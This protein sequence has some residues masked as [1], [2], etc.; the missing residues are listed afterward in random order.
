MDR[1]LLSHYNTELAHLRETAAEFAREFPK[2]ASRLA[3]DRDAKEICADPYVERLLEG[4][5]FLAARVQV[6][7]E[8]QFPKFTHGLLETV[9][10]HYLCPTPS[11]AIVQLEPILHDPN[12]AGGF[13]LPR[14]TTL[15]S[16][17]RRG[18]RTP[19]EYKTAHALTLWPIRIAE[20]RYHTRELLQFGLPSSLGA[21]AIL[22]I[23]LE[24]GAGVDFAQLPL[25]QLS[26]YIRGADDLPDAIFE[27]VF[28]HAT[29][30]VAAKPRTTPSLSQFRPAKQS[31]RQAGFSADQALLPE[32]SQTFSGYRLLREYFAL[33]QRFL[34]FEVA[35][36]SPLLAQC[37]GDALDLLL[38]FRE[39]DLRLENRV[40]VNSL[41]LFCTPAINLFERRL[42]RVVLD[43]RHHEYQVIPDKTRPFD[44]EV[45]QIQ[46]V[47]GYGART[48]EEQVFQ[49]FYLT[50]GRLADSSGR[51]EGG[52]SGFYASRREP[53]HLTVKERQFGRIHSYIGS[54][55]FLSLVDPNAAPYQTDLEQL[56][57]TALCTN[58]HLPLDLV[59]GQ[60]STD[61]ALDVNAPVN[62]IRCLS[63]PTAPVPPLA[64]G[65]EA[66]RLISHLSLNY[67]A[68][69]DVGGQ[70][71]AD[72]LREMLR[73]YVDPADRYSHKLIEGVLSTAVSPI[74]RKLPSPGAITFGRG[75]E[76]VVELDELA[77][78]GVGT[79][80]FG[81]VLA[82]FFRRYVSINS[83]VETAVRTKQRKE[84]M[85]W[86]AQ[87][88]RRGVV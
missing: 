85:R 86:P 61:L 69:E 56:G 72:V 11:M 88:G 83:F 63:G 5:A 24:A 65:A 40:D 71:G 22:Q 8:A 57:I 17:L 16:P 55:V 44:F 49:P 1:L 62:A 21:R 64:Q 82:E 60:G 29:G 41:A 10:P 3:L 45:F 28:R 48:G 50:R 37:H 75:I 78:E 31:L 30:I 39:Q 19:C 54:E 42:D 84:I 43:H 66:W 23:R 79:F 4:F 32:I 25:D 14:G 38:L 80:I 47:T 73:L 2:I 87:M 77:F 67:L 13:K 70:H 33:R 7:L 26:F 76:I 58:R 59:P 52:L 27:Q 36:L 18:Q 35:S 15:R 12:L 6:K 53:R 34:F 51:Q 74:I 46:S 81:S 9:Y 20:I 68:L